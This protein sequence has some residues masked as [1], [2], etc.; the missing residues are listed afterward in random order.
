MI[1]LIIPSGDLATAPPATHAAVEESFQIVGSLIP[2][3]FFF[4]IDMLTA[5]LSRMLLFMVKEGTTPQSSM[6]MVWFAAFVAGSRLVPLIYRKT[7][8]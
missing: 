3:V 4:S 2:A 6:V 1:Y 8:C 5:F 7:K